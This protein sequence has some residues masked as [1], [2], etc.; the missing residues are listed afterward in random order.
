MGRTTIG[1]L[2]TTV[3]AVVGLYLSMHR[4][5]SSPASP[6]AY[7]YIGDDFPERWNI[8]LTSP[9]GMLVQES[10]AYPMHGDDAMERW[11]TSTSDG[12]GYVR[13]GDEQR[14]F[15]AAMFHEMHCVRLMRAALSGRYDEMSRGHMTHCLNYIRQFILCTP[16]LTLEPPDILTRDFDSERIGSTHVCTDWSV[17]YDE[18]KVN[19][20]S[21]LQTQENRTSA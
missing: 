20:K 18:A 6:K 21:F 7:S 4:P 15:A 13:L 8:P 3:L 12:F 17:F 5:R 10:R 2:A 14:A 16:D 1:A 9:V 11:A 19:F